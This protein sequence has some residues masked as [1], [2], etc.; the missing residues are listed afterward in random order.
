MFKDL[1]KNKNIIRREMKNVKVNQMEFL[2][3][4]NTVPRIKN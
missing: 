4:D 3:L 1:N 2:E